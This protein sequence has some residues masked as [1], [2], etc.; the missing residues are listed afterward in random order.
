[1]DILAQTK[2]FVDHL[3]WN[4]LDPRMVL[5]IVRVTSILVDVSILLSIGRR[6]WVPANPFIQWV[7]ALLGC[8]IAL[9][10]PIA[11][12]TTVRRDLLAWVILFCLIAIICCPR[13][14][15]RSLT[16]AR[17][18]Q[19]QIERFLYSAALLAMAAQAVVTWVR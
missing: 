9:W 12:V 3:L 7:M 16:P 6:S 2:T 8:A 5:T 10:T 1:M 11:G 14:I 4:R 18:S 15:S 19:A 13:I 17:R